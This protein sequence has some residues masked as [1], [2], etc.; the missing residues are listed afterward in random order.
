MHPYKQLESRAFWASA[1]ANRGMAATRDLWDPQFCID[2]QMTVATF[3]SCFAQHFGRALRDREFRWLVTE[4]A[5]QGLTRESRAKFNYDVFSARTG[6]IYTTSMLGQWTAWALGERP[7]PGEVWQAGAR[8][9]DPFRPA[10]E[11]HG[12]ASEDEVLASRQ[13]TI[14]MFRQAIT[15]ADV[16]VFTMG[17]T[18]SWFNAE[19]GDEYPVCPGTAAGEF[20]GARHRFV[21]QDYLAIREALVKALAQIRSVNPEVSVLLTVSPV[22]LTATMSGNHV[23]T[24]TMESKA[25]LRAVA[26]SVARELSWVDYFPSYEIISAPAF[27]GAF[28]ED[29]KRTVAAAGVA[30]VMDCFFGSLGAK[31]PEAFTDG[32]AGEA[33]AAQDAAARAE[34]VACEEELL[35]AFGA[36]GG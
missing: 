32:F 22:P 15:K 10:V 19:S 25:I 6:N 36:R 4:R 34:T 17:L 20:D 8:Y 24:A 26:G 13:H 14:K 29:N 30:R 1:V 16:I 12:F 21:N 5:P 23:L 33:Q 9:F 27:G 11:P 35:A 18:E 2:Q 31:F 3:G 7:A 28:F